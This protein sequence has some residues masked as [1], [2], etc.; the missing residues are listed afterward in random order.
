MHGGGARESLLFAQAFR[1]VWLPPPEGNCYAIISGDVHHVWRN[2]DGLQRLFEEYPQL[3]PE[4]ER[5]LEMAAGD[6]LS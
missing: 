1:E 2:R 5:W 4:F 3:R 6:K